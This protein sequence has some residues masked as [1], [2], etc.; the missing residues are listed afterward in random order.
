MRV[1]GTDSSDSSDPA[2]SARSDESS[3]ASDKCDKSIEC[4]SLMNFAEPDAPG[5]AQQRLVTKWEERIAVTSAVKD[6]AQTL[7]HAKYT[8]VLTG[9]GV[10]TESG[11]PDFRSSRGLWRNM[12]AVR[13]LSLETLYYQ[14]EVF[15]TKGLELLGTMRGKKPNAAHKTLA[16]L[17]QRT[18]V[19]TVITQN[20]DGLHNESGS[21]RVLEIH[22][23]LRTSSCRDCRR[24][25][26]FEFLADAV[27]EGIV[28]PKCRCGGIV[29]PNVVF[30]GDPM[31][32]CFDEAVQVAQKAD[33]MLVVGSSLQVAPVAHLP[34]LAKQLAIINLEPTPYDGE[35]SIVIHDRAGTVLTR[36]LEYIKAQ[37]NTGISMG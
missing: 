16:W 30:F 2:E 24:E 18:L 9:A 17:E 5:A 10:S 28:P 25:T 12:D 26:P 14:P 21:N 32:P 11:I 19:D 15:Y 6:L 22:G 23:N 35:A 4:K 20:I 3:D 34:S 37:D 1:T 13:L 8:V 36:L 29:R 31:P 33:F 7:K 27:K